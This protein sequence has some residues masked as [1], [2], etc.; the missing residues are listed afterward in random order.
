[1]GE[2][3]SQ[4]HDE[5]LFLDEES[6]RLRRRIKGRVG[7]VDEKG[8]KI[9]KPEARRKIE[10]ALMLAVGLHHDQK[11][12][13]DGSRAVDHIL[14]VADRVLNSFGV[15]DPDIVIAA[16]LHDSVE[17]QKKKLA[18]KWWNDKVGQKAAAF[19]YL[20]FRF[21]PRT[22]DIVRALTKP[23]KADYANLK[24]RDRDY[25][26][27]LKED[28]KDPSTFYV[29]LADFYDNVSRLKTVRS[30]EKQRQLARKYQ[31]VVSLFIKRLQKN[32]VALP[33]SEEFPEGKASMIAQLREAKKVIADILLQ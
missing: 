10:E 7:A 6:L 9:F 4:P 1:M 26:A 15:I 30:I 25:F 31:K 5:A 11:P 23:N 33:C 22:A 28:I 8:L 12:R 24:D 21:G 32:D 19:L 14:R 16:L 29:K 20:A 2:A 13:N 17:D 27:Q 18:E 3:V